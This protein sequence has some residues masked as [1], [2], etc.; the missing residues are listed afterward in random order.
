MLIKKYRIKETCLNDFKQVNTVKSTSILEALFLITEPLNPLA[1]IKCNQYRGLK[2]TDWIYLFNDL[3]TTNP[4]EI[5]DGVKTLQIF[6]QDDSLIL[7]EGDL[8]SRIIDKSDDFEITKHKNEMNAT[9]II[10]S[11]LVTRFHKVQMQK[12]ISDLVEILQRIEPNLRNLV[13]GLEQTIY[14]DIG[15]DQLVPLSCLGSKFRNLLLYAS[16][17]MTFPGEI[18][19]IN[20]IDKTLQGATFQLAYKY[21]KQIFVS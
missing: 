2:E 16:S 6:Y 11:S 5:S 20:D 15:L 19:L 1:V 9:F 14:V 3:N 21:N 18:I 7:K 12:Q 8:E 13:L 17:V 4:I 10:E